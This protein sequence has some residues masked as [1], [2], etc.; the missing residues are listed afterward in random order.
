LE[1]KLNPQKIT[2]SFKKAGVWAFFL[3]VFTGGNGKNVLGG[4]SA[5]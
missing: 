1:E 5:R 4:F 2:A 3:N